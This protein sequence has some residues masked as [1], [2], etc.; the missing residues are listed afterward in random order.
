[1]H[2]DVHAGP[3][4]FG[5]VPTRYAPSGPDTETQATGDSGGRT[6]CGV[7]EAVSGCGIGVTVAGPRVAHDRADF[8]AAVGRERWV[9]APRPPFVK[10]VS[11][12]AR[13]ATPGWSRPHP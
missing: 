9:D 2:A 13:T 5:N 10:I 7:V 6:A 4:D 12:L 3:D 8:D 11:S 1:M